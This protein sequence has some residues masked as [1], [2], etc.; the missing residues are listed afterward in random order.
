[1]VKETID[2][3]SKRSADESQSTSAG[4]DED[5]PDKLT[6]LCSPTGL[7]AELNNETSELTDNENPMLNDND[8]SVPSSRS[9]GTPIN[10]KTNLP[11]SSNRSMSGFSSLDKDV[12]NVD[13]FLYRMSFY[14]VISWLVLIALS[15]FAAPEDSIVR[16][17][18]TERTAALMELCVLTTAV[19]MRHGILLWDMK[20]EVGS[21]PLRISGVLAGG[22]TV[23]FV[24]VFT[25]VW[26]V[27]FPVPVMIDPVFHSRVHL[28][29]WCEWTPLAG[30]MTLLMQCIDAPTKEDGKW[31]TKFKEKT[32]TASLESISTFCGMLF[33]FCPNQTCWIACMIISFITYSSIFFSY[34]KRAKEFRGIV[35]GESED[36]IELY[37][38][39]RLSLAL[40]WMCCFSWTMITGKCVWGDLSSS[41]YEEDVQ[42]FIFY[43]IH[44]SLPPFSILL[45]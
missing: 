20:P 43:S 44:Y 16:L 3:P 14:V 1:M 33:P 19:I 17:T 4:P 11:V 45:R 26:M 15:Y 34:V 39:S 25:V 29:R 10:A 35:R 13:L 42:I 6:A 7:T 30:F 8:D 38:R 18:G 32:L 24:A 2:M 12:E 37:E 40:H 22:L 9:I 21:I 23:Q 5:D 36:H 41:Y 27:A 28:L 31:S